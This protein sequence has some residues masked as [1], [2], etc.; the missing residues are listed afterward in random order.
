MPKAKPCLNMLSNREI[1][2]SPDYSIRL[3]GGV[4]LGEGKAKE[5]EAFVIV[6]TAPP[7]RIKG[8][9]S[10]FGPWF[11]LMEKFEKSFPFM[12]DSLQDRDGI[13]GERNNDT[14]YERG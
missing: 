5:A 1:P 3:V 10:F 14:N 7:F 13:G 9:F 6:A 4:D 2:R 11:F 12:S 8:L